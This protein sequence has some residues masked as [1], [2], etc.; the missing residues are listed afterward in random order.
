MRAYSMDLRT[1]VLAA[2]DGG[3][4]TAAAATRFSVS[5]VMSDSPISHS[6]TVALPA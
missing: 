5:P 6:T 3:A 2:L 4:G 1:R